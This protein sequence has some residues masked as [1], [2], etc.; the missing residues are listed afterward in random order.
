MEIVEKINELGLLEVFFNEDNYNEKEIE[1]EA[2]E[3]VENN[4]DYLET[5][6]G[7]V[8]WLDS[9]EDTSEFWSIVHFVDHNIYVKIEGEFDSYMQYEHSYDSIKEVFPKQVTQTVYE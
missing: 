4:Q 6:F 8:E 1:N 3:M 9:R 2:G 7:K 5:I